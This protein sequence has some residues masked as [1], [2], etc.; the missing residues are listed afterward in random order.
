MLPFPELEGA[1]ELL[2]GLVDGLPPAF[3]DGL[4]EM[5]AEAVVVVLPEAVAGGVLLM[6]GLAEAGIEAPVVCGAPA[7]GGGGCG[8]G[9]P[10]D[11]VGA[12][13]FA[14]A[15]PPI[16]V[17]M[18]FAGWAG[19]EGGGVSASASSVASSPSGVTGTSA[20][21]SPDMARWS[22]SPV[23]RLPGGGGGLLRSPGW[24]GA[25]RSRTRR[26]LS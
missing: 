20:S 16:A 13:G 19:V 8:A 24:A 15:G 11:A 5:L 18:A 10:A 4:V 22:G 23:L 14:A 1:G 7:G 17:P 21:S 2:G 6:G 12:S 9:E 3:E 26:A 25:L